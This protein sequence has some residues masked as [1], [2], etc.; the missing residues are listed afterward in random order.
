MF[1]IASSSS[2]TKLLSCPGEVI[3]IFVAISGF[4]I[5][6]GKLIRAICA[7]FIFG[8]ISKDN[9]VLE[10]TIPLTSSVSLIPSLCTFSIFIL[11]RSISSSFAICLIAITI[12]F[13]KLSLAPSAP[14][15]VI[16]VIA[17]CSKT[18]L[19]SEVILKDISFKIL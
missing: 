11:A 19:S 9:L 18:S 12:I 6:R 17:I 2:S 5:S 3:E 16:A 1:L 15:P 8:G 4:L 10:N 13:A 7:L 14:F